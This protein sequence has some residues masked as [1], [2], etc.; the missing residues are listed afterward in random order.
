MP[1][2]RFASLKGLGTK[3]RAPLVETDIHELG[4]KRLNPEE[5]VIRQREELLAKA[6]KYRI[7]GQDELENP[8]RALG[9]K[10]QYTEIISKLRRIAPKLKAIDGSPGN[11]ALYF[12]RNDKDLEATAREWDWE[13]DQKKDPF[14]RL[15]RYVGGFPKG[16][17]AEYS[18]VDIDTSL[19]PTREN[20]G[21][22]SVL[23]TLIKQGV[24]SYSDAVS[25]FGD[26]GHDKRGWRWNEQLR[27]W[28]F[29]AGTKFKQET[30]EI[31]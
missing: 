15:N 19:L 22:R 14:F 9:P 5:G 23:I 16:D 30:Q 20:R 11:I 6:G 4:D 28:K 27:P 31:R 18:T 29:L 3:N 10:L 24:I 17:L 25:E 8:E 2:G 21:W 7:Y 26:V 13:H 12:P 1:K